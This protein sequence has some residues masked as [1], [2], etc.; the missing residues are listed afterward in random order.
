MIEH[1]ESRRAGAIA[2]GIALAVLALA[3]GPGAA[4]DASESAALV[5]R[6]RL[7]FAGVMADPNLGPVVRR[8]LQHARAIIIAP[9]IL[10]GAFIVGVSGG[11]AVMLARDDRGGWAGPAFLTIAGASLGLQAGGDSSE[12]ILLA[13]TG[14]G[15]SGLL[16]HSVKLGAD[17]GVALGPVGI[18][19]AAETVN[20]SADVVAWSRARGAYAGASLKGAVVATRD[21]WNHAYYGRD[22][23]P[24]DILVR[25]QATNPRSRELVD[26][27]ADAARGQ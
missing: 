4:D 26:A 15:V 16:S 19:A 8:H 13:M 5:D 3:A 1:A 18:G 24:I 14:R 21:D 2:V 10:R 7:T 23:T 27:V 17:V 6:A 20:I 22:V 11:S 9:Q 25:Y 12:V